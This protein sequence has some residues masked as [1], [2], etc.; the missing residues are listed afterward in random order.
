[1]NEEMPV[2]ESVDQPNP[3]QGYIDCP[4]CLPR[5]MVAPVLLT[6]KGRLYTKCPVHD[7]NLMTNNASQQWIRDHMRDTPQHKPGDPEPGPAPSPEEVA[8]PT[9]PPAETKKTKRSGGDW[10]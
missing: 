1:M 2:H 10:W 5:L 9:A 8:A 7:T 3:I 4:L 6:K